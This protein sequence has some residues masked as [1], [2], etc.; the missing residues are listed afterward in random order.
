M[1]VPLAG[2]TKPL[3]SN[4]RE[5]FFQPLS[6]PRRVSGLPTETMI[7]R[8]VPSTDML[9]SALRSCGYSP[10][11]EL[12]VRTTLTVRLLFAHLRSRWEKF[13]QRV[14]GVFR[15]VIASSSTAGVWVENRVQPVET[16]LREGLTV[17]VNSNSLL[18]NRMEKSGGS[19]M[20]V[21]V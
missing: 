5:S 21:S 16:T 1:T 3:S 17:L 13:C 19:A 15:L 20:E 2:D 4:D 7:I 18:S 12:T 6:L 8:L 10:L 11:L 9:D 14:T